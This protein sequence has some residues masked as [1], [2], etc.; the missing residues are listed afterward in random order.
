MKLPQ[1]ILLGA[2]Y[3]LPVAFR[4]ND[5]G[6]Y[7]VCSNAIG[8]RVGRNVLRQNLDTRLG[9][10]IRNGGL[11]VRSSTGSR[12]YGDNVAELPFLH[13]R[14]DAFAGQ[15]GCREIA[16]DG[17]VP[18]FFADLL[19][20]SGLSKATPGIRNQDINRSEGLF[21]LTP[22]G[23]NFDEPGHLSYHLCRNPTLALNARSDGGQGRRVPSVDTDLCPF[24][25]EKTSDRR[26]D[27]P[28]RTRNDCDS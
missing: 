16:V 2:G 7:A 15:K 24:L 6:R 17:C 10:G 20:W 12:G 13:S 21:H 23:F 14:D 1:R 9:G 26:P 3:A 8:T 25:R 4:E 5:L 19:Q 18:A 27:P 28:T 11:R 22:H